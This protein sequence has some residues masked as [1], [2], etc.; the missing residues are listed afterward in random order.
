MS[1]IINHQ[2]IDYQ[3]KYLTL[4]HSM[5]E[6]Y[7][8]FI[9]NIVIGEEEYETPLP[10]YLKDFYMES[11]FSDHDCEK[12]DF[13]IYQL[14]NIEWYLKTAEEKEFV[15]DDDLDNYFAEL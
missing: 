14:D 5:K 6:F 9:T 15:L 2:L 13:P 12:D 11:W 8:S 1:L 4:Q 7:N 3:Q 10:D